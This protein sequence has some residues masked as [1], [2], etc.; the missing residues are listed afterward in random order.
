VNLN[1]LRLIRLFSFLLLL[2][3]GS[4]LAGDVVNGY[5][6]LWKIETPRGQVSYLFGTMHV[7]DPEV[8]KLPLP[9]EQAFADS[10]LFVMEMIPDGE[11]ASYLFEQMMYADPTQSLQQVL[12]RRLYRKVVKAMKPYGFTREQVDRFKPWAILLLL[13]VPPQEGGGDVLDES[14][15]YKAKARKIPTHGLETIQEQ[16]AVFAEGFTEQEMEVLLWTTVK[17][18][19][20]QEQQLEEMKRLYLNRDLAGLVALSED[21]GRQNENQAVFEKLG[22][23]LLTERNYRMA[24]RMPVY[25]KQGG[26]FIAVGAL[27]LPGEEG[28]IEL[29]RKQGYKVERA[30]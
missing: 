9:V 16:I 8:V 20:R 13:S 15:R 28:L 6:L 7:A 23:R 2:G 1:P 22:H 12:P 21:D 4:L 14:L 17:Q 18:G 30:Y 11:A 3:S 5:G 25:L 24:E 10:T 19:H 27:H 26:A 29:L